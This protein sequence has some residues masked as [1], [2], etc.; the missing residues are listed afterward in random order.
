ME[1]A[2]S[3]KITFE[4]YNNIAKVYADR[5]MDEPLY[6]DTYDF[7]CSLLSNPDAAILEVGCGPGNITKYLL[8]KIPT[9]QITA[10]DVAPNMLDIAKTTNPRAKFMLM[11]CRDMDVIKNKF[12]AIVSGFCFPYLS[13]SDCEKFIHDGSELL[14]PKGVLY[15]SMIEGDYNKSG[16]ESGSNPQ[17]KVYVYYHQQAQMEAYLLTY[18]FSVVRVIKKQMATTSH[19]SGMHTIF[20]ASK[21]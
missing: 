13:K 1:N 8:S 17:H 4:T 16:Y 20:I 19:K 3:Y 2:D 9:L 18:G 5:F 10:T 15:F 21:N 6:N 7:F 12:D 11:D 14:N